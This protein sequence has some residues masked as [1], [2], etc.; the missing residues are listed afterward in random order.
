MPSP[1]KEKKQEI[2]TKLKGYLGKCQAV[3]FADYR[4]L[5][6]SQ[7]SDLRQKL[8]EVGAQLSVAKNTLIKRALRET[9][10]LSS[11]TSPFELEG[12]TAAIFAQEDQIVPLK[13]I[14]LFAKVH[15]LP[16]L[17]GGFLA[18]EYLSGQEVERL[19]LLPT[20]D[21]LLGQTVG[22]ISAPFY[23]LIYALQANLQSLV[24]VLGANIKKTN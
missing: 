1:K 18:K 13:T 22:Q 12:P 21:V 3:F 23:A 7:I 20:Y 11:I 6:V 2:L 16:R 9:S 24:Y 8:K 5:T 19:A 10:R 15:G 17:K 14:A 4:G